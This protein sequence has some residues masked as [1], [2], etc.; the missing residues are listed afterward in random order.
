MT[1]LDDYIW[2]ISQDADPWL[3]DLARDQRPVHQQLARLRKRLTKA[4]A[5][6]VVQQVALRRRA[7]CKFGPW[8]E[9][10]FFT[11]IGLQQATDRWLAA[12][13]AGRFPQSVTV[14]DLCCGIGGDLQ[15][16]AS[17]GI[18]ARSQVPMTHQLGCQTIGWDLC[19]QQV[20]L[21]EANLRV[22]PKQA[23]EHRTVT[24]TGDVET[25][26]LPPGV[27]WHIDPDRRP[28]QR[29]ST[30]MEYHRPG[31]ALVARLLASHPDGAIKLA[32]ACQVPMNWSES[33]ELEWISRDRECRQL[34]VWFGNLANGAGQRRATTLSRRPTLSSAL[35]EQEVGNPPRDPLAIHSFVGHSLVGQADRS[36]PIAQTLGLYLFDPDPAVLAA[37]LLGELAHQ[38]GLLALVPGGAYL[39][40]D[41]PAS[42]PLLAC[43]EVLEQ[44]PLRIKPLAKFLAACDIGRLEIKKRGIHLDPTVLR[45]Q[46]RLRGTRSAT[47]LLTRL[48]QREIA[49]LAQRWPE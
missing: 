41:H 6:L 43:F 24:R 11:D 10:M 3:V 26:Q 23:R 2:L 20:L 25:L 37:N 21:A 22:I 7:V 19:E 1:E 13:K 44:F 39:T 38:Q 4:R 47:L 16:L 5:Q 17:R 34:V 27:M 35:T 42:D 45:K 40:A 30:Q 49:I 32:P 15:G 46:L 14:H 31:P 12:Y 48:G 33:A 36:L 9:R 28:Q 18:P 8:G 29:R